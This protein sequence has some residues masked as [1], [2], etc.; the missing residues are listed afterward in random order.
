MCI[1]PE[2]EVKMLL[3]KSL[4]PHWSAWVGSF[5][6][7]SGTTTQD[8][9][10]AIINEEDRMKAEGDKQD[11][12]ALY[13]RANT[14]ATQRKQRPAGVGYEPAPRGPDGK[15]DFSSYLCWTCNKKGHLQVNRPDYTASQQNN[16]SC[17]APPK[18][19][20][21]AMT[22]K[23]DPEAQHKVPIATAGHAASTA[24]E[25][26]GVASPGIG[27]EDE[28]RDDAIKATSGIAEPGMVA[29]NK[30]AYN[31][32]QSIIKQKNGE[33]KESNNDAS[34]APSAVT[35][36]DLVATNE[37]VTD[38]EITAKTLS[39]KPDLT[40]SGTGWILDTGATHHIS[41]NVDKFVELAPGSGPKKIYFGDNSMHKAECSGRAT[42]ATKIGELMVDNCLYVP[43]VPHNLLS[44]RK[45][46][47]DGYE[48]RF[49]DRNWQIL[50]GQTVIVEGGLRDGLYWLDDTASALLARSQADG[51]AEL[52]H[53]RLAH[54]GTAAMKRI[55][56]MAEG[57][58]FNGELPETDKCEGCLQGKHTRSPLSHESDFRA[59][60]PM[61][62]VHSDVCG[63]LPDSLFGK[64]YFFHSSIFRSSR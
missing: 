45:L 29:A 24:N 59:S 52:R 47:P 15:K 64:R 53:R 37:L 10:N 4:P 32:A 25:E 46:T 5:L 61:D 63:P 16:S 9:L 54:I 12:Q 49:T 36:L 38:L 30:S 22:V 58:V 55:E 60:E 8:T 35:G 7:L 1:F 27:I 19:G 56:S 51:N 17:V 39:L 3:T 26:E 13:T 57:V 43:E 44:V 34:G 31:E 23:S 21:T 20:V 6:L 18:Y 14:R 41:G 50:D 28:G 2:M 40:S 62:L 42:M 11:A 48:A 33:E